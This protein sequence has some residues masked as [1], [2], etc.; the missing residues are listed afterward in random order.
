M[1]EDTKRRDVSGRRTVV[2]CTL[3]I[4]WILP[5]KGGSAWELGKEGRSEGGVNWE[6]KKFRGEIDR[7]D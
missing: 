7:N 1:R 4:L 5:L 2:L 6:P 3:E